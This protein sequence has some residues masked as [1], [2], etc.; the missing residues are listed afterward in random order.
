MKPQLS[1][2]GRDR[3]D[4]GPLRPNVL[5]SLYADR[6]GITSRT[7]QSEPDDRDMSNVPSGLVDVESV[8][9]WIREDRHM[10]MKEASRYLG[11]SERKF[12]THIK[13][14]PRFK[15]G[16]MW[17]VKKSELDT[18]MEQHRVWPED[19]EGL[20]DEVMGEIGE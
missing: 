15:V 18:W 20:V 7:T 19:V 17:L 4:Q 11:M 3:R 13:Q 12:G 8:L 1:A 5:I 16:G 14:I 10:G 9:Q 6:V 2:G